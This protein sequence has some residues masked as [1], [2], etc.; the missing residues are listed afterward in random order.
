MKMKFKRYWIL[1]SV[2]FMVLL[3][4]SKASLADTWKRLGDI[5]AQPRNSF[6]ATLMNGEVYVTGGWPGLTSFQV[7]DPSTDTWTRKADQPNG[8]ESYGACAVDGILYVIGGFSGGLLNTVEAYDPVT[9]TWTRK[10]N[11]IIPRGGSD[12]GVVDGIIYAIGGRVQ[13]E[14]A[15]VN[16]NI[17]EAYDPGT[18]TWTRKA[19][20]INARRFAVVS[21]ID[22]RI[23][24][25]GG[26]SPEVSLEMYDPGTDT[27]TPLVGSEQQGVI[28]T[29]WAVSGAVLLDEKSGDEKMYIMGG[30]PT[31]NQIWV[32]NPVSNTL[33]LSDIQMSS[34]KG[35]AGDFVFNNKIYIMGGWTAGKGNLVDVW[36]YD[37][38]A[39]PPAQQI[40][41]VDAKGKQ[42][43]IWGTLKIAE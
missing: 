6:R 31:L 18:D 30:W 40:R 35:F 15:T 26:E 20:M 13:I 4:N 10:A 11:M 24:V 43:S 27:W 37:P 17:T 21:V 2:V 5:P 23:Y 33:E 3:I 38:Y 42:P 41:N 36:V 16:T 8:R 12:V 19:G 25:A 14:N 7:Y 1:S 29:N 32:Y 28:L 22:G 39:A 9:D 34:P